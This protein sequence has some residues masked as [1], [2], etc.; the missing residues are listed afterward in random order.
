MI[1]IY[2]ITNKVNGKVYIGQSVDIDRRIKEHYR[3]SQP[4]VYA[5]RNERDYKTPIHLAMNK[6][7]IH[8][9]SI[10][11]LEECNKEDLDDKEIYWINVYK[12]NN[13]CFGYNLTNGGQKSFA[14]Q[15][16]NHSQA[17]LTKTEVNEI[18]NL[19]RY[20]DKTI[21]EISKEFPKVGKATISSINIGSI[22]NHDEET[23]PL[24]KP[25]YSSPGE[26]N[27][28]S[29]FSDEEVMDIR[30]KH[31]KGVKFIEIYEEYKNKASISSI[32]K[33]V[34]GE[35]YK[36]LPIWKSSKKEWV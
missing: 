1:G 2:L 25:N 33:I 27:P 7:G 29:K 20:S 4:E 16:E 24:R 28:Q 9:F 3:S 12:S 10:K 26:K 32:K 5:L 18:K 36:H 11:V 34:Y 22:W 17:K 8:N 13:K 19:L 21:S 31:S 23:Y 15:G 30:V 14:L 6:Y 35:N